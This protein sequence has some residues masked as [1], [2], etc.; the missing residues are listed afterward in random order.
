MA[1][2]QPNLT[3][4]AKQGNAKAIPALMNCQLQPKDITA[5]TMHTHKD[6][7]LGMILEADAVQTLT[8]T[9]FTSRTEKLASM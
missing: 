4:L 9:V 5:K 1:Q 2:T 6:C 8:Q 7:W 3:Q